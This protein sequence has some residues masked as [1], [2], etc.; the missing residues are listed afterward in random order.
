MA[1]CPKCSGEMGQKDATCPHCGYD[2]P[3]EGNERI[4]L[5]DSTLADV[6]LMVGAVV[7]GFSCLGSI[8]YSVVMLCQG[9]VLQGLVV[10]PIGFFW[11]LAMVVV[12]L[13]VQKI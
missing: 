5:E 10:G 9:Q 2:F 12:F 13:R 11:S 7:A 6:A 4:W 8:L 3:T 1:Y